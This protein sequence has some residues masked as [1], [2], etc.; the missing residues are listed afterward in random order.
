MEFC[1][2]CGNMYYIMLNKKDNNNITYHCRKCGDENTEL[3]KDLK[4]LCVSK[5]HI[6]N[7]NTNYKNII[8]EYTKLD[9]TLPRT[10]KVDCPN[11]NC[12]SNVKIQ[13]DEKKSNSSKKKCKTEKEIIYIRYNHNNMKYMYLCCIC[14]T[15]WKNDDK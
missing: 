12:P 8:N 3:I 15:T 1:N 9:P 5:T 4:N 13:E 14:D 11:E 7:N 6:I 10:N 2:K